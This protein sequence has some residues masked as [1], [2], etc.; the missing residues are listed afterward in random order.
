M[1]ITTLVVMVLVLTVNLLFSL[2]ALAV[3]LMLARRSGQSLRSV[4]WSPRRGLSATFFPP[5]DEQ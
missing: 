5:W 2:I 1:A 4:S 3:C